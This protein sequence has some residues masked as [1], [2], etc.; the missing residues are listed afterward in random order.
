MFSL[1]NEDPECNYESIL[2]GWHSDRR[3]QASDK[4]E[5]GLLNYLKPGFGF[6][7]SCF[8]KD[9]RAL[10]SSMLVSGHEENLISSVINRNSS[11]LMEISD[12]ITKSVN[13]SDEVL[14]LGIA[15]KESTDDTR[16]SPSIRLIHELESRG[17]KVSWHDLH[18]SDGD[19]RISGTRIFDLYGTGFKHIILCNHEPYYSDY[20]N[21][22]KNTKI[23]SSISV[24]AL[25][26]Q[27]AILGYQWLIPRQGSNVVT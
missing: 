23:R 17:F 16:E 27:Q 11:A 26:Y 8:P 19:N 9:L 3:F 1:F 25:R 4:N 22:E 15:F 7:G 5:L 13:K 18:I 24:Y 2:S 12:W 20:L 10:Y 14:L 21:E 6:G